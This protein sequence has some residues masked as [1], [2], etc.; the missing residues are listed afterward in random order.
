MVYWGG[1]G[2]GGLLPSKRR[3]PGS[4]ILPLSIHLAFRS[5]SRVA[6]VNT[7]E[8]MA[9]QSRKNSPSSILKL[10]GGGMYENM[11]NHSSFKP[12]HGKLIDV[13]LRLIASQNR[14]LREGSE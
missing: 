2:G 6:L 4:R 3:R 5:H 14:F 8:E 7:A 11:T 10:V 9:A 13:T 1:G 12:N